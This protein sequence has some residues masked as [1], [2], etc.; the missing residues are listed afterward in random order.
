MQ[1]IG[2]HSFSSTSIFVHLP[3][4]FKWNDSL[5]VFSVILLKRWGEFTEKVKISMLMALCVD[6][7]RLVHLSVLSLKTF[8]HLICI[9]HEKDKT[10]TSWWDVFSPYW[11]REIVIWFNAF[12]NNK[13]LQSV[14]MLFFCFWFAWSRAKELKVSLCKVP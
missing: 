1:F 7:R 14:V 9:Y 6:H 5:M 12:R 13:G 11:R 10:F 4:I 8:I 3:Y 2:L